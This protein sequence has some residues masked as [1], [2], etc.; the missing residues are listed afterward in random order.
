M[1][2]ETKEIFSE[3][4]IDQLIEVG[5]RAIYETVKST[6]DD[7]AKQW[8]M[9]ADKWLSGEDK[10]E[11]TAHRMYYAITYTRKT[12]GKVAYRITF[13]A[14]FQSMNSAIYAI[15]DVFANGFDILPIIDEVKKG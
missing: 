6:G 3:L 11:I 10:T 2:K 5:I 15:A 7:W 9:W 8:I 13:A 4:S 1:I 14:Y 12:I